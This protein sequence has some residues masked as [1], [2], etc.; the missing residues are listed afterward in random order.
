M[1]SLNYDKYKWLNTISQNKLDDILNIGYSLITNINYET[2][3]NLNTESQLDDLVDDLKDDMDNKH[4]D[5]INKLEVHK[6]DTINKIQL[7]NNNSHKSSQRLGV[8]GEN[9]VERLLY[10]NLKNISIESTA[11]QSHMSDFIVNDD[12]LKVMLEV[13]NYSKCVPYKEVEKL[14]RDMEENKIKYGLFISFNQNI[15][16]IPGLIHYEEIND[17]YIIYLSNVTID[18]QLSIIIGYNFLKEISKFISNES[19]RKSS[20]IKC[21]DI[22]YNINYE[23]NNMD[24]ILN[25][26]I[27]NLKNNFE[28]LNDDHKR[29]ADNILNDIYTMKHQYKTILDNISGKMVGDLTELGATLKTPSISELVEYEKKI[30]SYCSIPKYVD[31]IFTNYKDISILAPYKLLITNKDSQ[32]EITFHKKTINLYNHN[33]HIKMT[34]EAKS[35]LKLNSFI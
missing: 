26:N 22:V 5:I 14:K 17:G 15:C 31:E 24:E 16:K 10:D 20:K 11:Q 9:V 29:N 19:L 7:I 34:I 35:E 13:K 28:K 30:R 4:N 32:C 1:V 12:N 3:V 2:I 6:L 27:M 25:K 33:T 18:S 8:E 23:L 21:Q